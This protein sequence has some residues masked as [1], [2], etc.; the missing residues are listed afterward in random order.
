MNWGYQRRVSERANMS[1]F[2]DH[3]LSLN[4][5]EAEINSVSETVEEKLELWQIVDEL[6]HHKML[7]TIL[8]NLHEDHHEEFLTSLYERPHDKVIM[9]YLKEKIGENVEEL[10]R[11]EIGNLAS[12]ILKEIRSK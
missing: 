7:D 4:E 10:L 6:V 11:Q 8:G 5:V 3:L 12:E 1:T 2:F 9:R